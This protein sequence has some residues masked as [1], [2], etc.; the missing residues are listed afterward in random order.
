MSAPFSWRATVSQAADSRW[1]LPAI[2]VI[3]LIA[4]L[5]TLGLLPDQDFPDARVYAESGR[6]LATSGI[7][8]SPIYMPLYPLWTWIWG[9]AWGVR[10]GDVLLSSITIALI[11]RLSVTLFQDRAAALVAAAAA[12][13]YP[14]FL[15]YAV[16]GLTE[17]AFTFLLWGAFLSLYQG[18]YVAGSVFLV[19]G[20]LV[21]PAIDL[22]APALVFLFAMVTH[23]AP[24]RA[25]LFRVGQY[26]LVYVVLMGPWWAH[27]YAKYGE[28]VRLNPGDGIPFYS[29]N[30]PMNRSGGGVAGQAKESDM[31]L[32][33]FYAIKDPIERNAALKEAAWT[34]IRENPGR[35]LELAGVKFVR[36]WR[37]WPYAGEYEKPSIIATSVLSYG[38]FLVL[39]LV[40]LVRDGH[41]HLRVLTPVLVLA[42]Y[43]TA[44]HM[45]TIGSIR[46]RFPLEP[47]LLILGSLLISRLFVERGKA[48]IV[49]A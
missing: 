28:F 24:L 37:L 10:L 14:H 8:S 41:R 7:M 19:L 12:A 40:F 45:V 3:G 35:F 27:N 9:G 17:T 1:S 47:A 15:F 42:A 6:S 33:P 34:F 20:I 43:L 25:A 22:L 18:R 16:S 49:R 36:F 26:A 23:R 30:N 32:A 13:I 31:D 46:Y 21:R 4:R 2:V 5:I 38:S 11:Y 39:S 29:G 44:V 48:S